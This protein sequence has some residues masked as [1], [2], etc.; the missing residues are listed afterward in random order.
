MMMGPIQLMLI[1][2]DAAD[3]FAGAIRKEI[4]D[5]RRRGLLRLI[6]LLF[7]AKTSDGRL[8]TMTYSDMN[9][10]QSEEFG[11]AIKKMLGLEE[12]EALT[13]AHAFELVEDSLGLSARDV[14]S[15]AEAIE[16][17]EAALVLLVEHV[18]AGKLRAAIHESG[19]RMAMQAL[20]TKDALALIGEELRAIVEAERTIE[21][22]EGIRGAAMLDALMAVSEAEEAETEA[23]DL[24]AADLAAYEDVLKNQV[25]AE[26]LRALAASGVVDPSEVTRALD[27]LP[28]VGSERWPLRAAAGGGRG[29]S[30]DGA[31]RARRGRARASRALEDVTGIPAL[32]Q[33]YRECVSCVK[34]GT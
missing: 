4:A 15:L 28:L 32:I 5:L 9:A 26:V 3:R 14:H 19:G 20:L 24:A 10:A 33:P 1:K 18:W 11:A 34:F 30:G 21:L 2:F 6:D 31:I 12:V 27:S 29:R 8:S 17:G 25:T 7:V 23:A 22:A 16:P 13:D